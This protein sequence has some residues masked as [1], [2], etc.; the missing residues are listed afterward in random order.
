MALKSDRYEADTDI[1]FYYN[2]GTAT[3]GGVVVYDTGGA[4]GAAMDQGSNL[5]RYKAAASGD[6]PVG[7]LLNDVVNKD[8]TRLH[9]NVYKDEV[10]LGGKVTIGK[11]GWWVTNMVDGV[12]TP[13][14]RGHIA[15]ASAVNAGLI[16]NSGLKA[17]AIGR[18]MGSRD[19]DGYY[20]VELNLP[21][22][23]NA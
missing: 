15:Y 17:H 20:K 11:K 3:R 10:Q 19:P 13:I 18:F 6:V 2:A 12:S 5:V 7:L 8:L 21:T 4:S 23:V 22:S 16:T 14:V 1:S 9:M